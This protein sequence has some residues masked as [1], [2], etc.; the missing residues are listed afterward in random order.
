MSVPPGVIADIGIGNALS[1]GRNPTGLKNGNIG[2]SKNRDIS[3][4]PGYISRLSARGMISLRFF[5]ILLF[6]LPLVYILGHGST[7]LIRV[8]WLQRVGGVFRPV[9]ERDKVLQCQQLHNFPF[10]AD[11]PPGNRRRRCF[12][13]ESCVFAAQ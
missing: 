1:S 8:I 4:C 2:C 7:G 9:P 3:G 5:W 13:S 10:P 11:T 12:F 6:S